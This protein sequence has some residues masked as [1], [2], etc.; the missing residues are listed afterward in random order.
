[1]TTH[2]GENITS[3][4]HNT[5]TQINLEEQKIMADT[6]TPPQHVTGLCGY[7]TNVGLSALCT[8]G[9]Y[10]KSV[11]PTY[12]ITG[13]KRSF[14]NMRTITQ[15]E[16]KAQ[17]IDQAPNA[18]QA[19]FNDD[20]LDYVDERDKFAESAEDADNAEDAE[21]A[22]NA[23]DAEDAEDAENAED[24][25]DADVANDAKD[26]DVANDAK[27]AEHAKVALIT[28]IADGADITYIA[29]IADKTVEADNEYDIRIAKFENVMMQSLMDR[30][31]STGSHIIY[32]ILTGSHIIDVA[33]KQRSG[34]GRWDPVYTCKG[35]VFNSV[36]KLANFVDKPNAQT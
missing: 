33:A 17:T 15:A 10:I 31:I 27:D 19:C 30:D 12:T 26:A 9:K 32:D 6:I 2:I 7:C 5:L 36:R 16:N 3:A 8:V 22:E 20:Y 11:L 25:E 23:E 4:C 18:K 14:A 21:D 34:N 29:D 28:Y 35:K 13:K 1:L 24:A